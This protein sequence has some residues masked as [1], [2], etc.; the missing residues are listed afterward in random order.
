VHILHTS[1]ILGRAARDF[2][3]LSVR[4]IPRA[5]VILFVTTSCGGSS[6]PGQIDGMGSGS[7][8]GSGSGFHD[9]A[10]DVG[11][12][13]F[14][15]GG[16]TACA[17]NQVCCAM[18]SNTT[19]TFSCVSEGACPAADKIACDGPDECGGGTPVCC[20][21]DVPSGAGSYPQCDA[22]SVGTS[23]TSAAACPTHLAG[24]CSDTTKVQICHVASECSDP[25][26]PKCCTFMSGGAELTFCT[27][28]V[29]AQFGG[30]TC[31]P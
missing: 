22:Q 1:R 19:T 16:N 2:G 20:G 9:A 4:M 7:G 13:D 21:V 15:C 30:A 3:R 5:I 17:L 14:G 31:H 8:S 10:V 11:V 29:T 18:P 23:C 24:S 27:D 28:S 26:N 12:Y 6:S 25:N